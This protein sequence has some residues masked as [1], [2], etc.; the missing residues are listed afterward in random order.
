MTTASRSARVATADRRDH[1]R[2]PPAI[3][4]TGTGIAIP[5]PSSTTTGTRST[6]GAPW[7][8]TA[9][10]IAAKRRQTPS[11]ADTRASWQA[12]NNPTRTRRFS[13]ICGSG[14]GK[15]RDLPAMTAKPTRKSRLARPLT[16]DRSPAV[17]RGRPAYH[18]TPARSRPAVRLV[19]VAAV[20]HLPTAT[21][22]SLGSYTTPGDT[23]LR[24]FHICATLLS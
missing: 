14:Q 20:G 7:S 23:T 12:P 9:C 11:V 6:K 21:T 2:P 8:I 4:S 17:R 10:G 18:P 3:R 22:G 24:P 15:P 1:P 5:S 13:R 16:A 19:A